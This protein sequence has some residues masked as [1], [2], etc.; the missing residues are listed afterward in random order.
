MEV[1]AMKMTLTVTLALLFTIVTLTFA[2]EQPVGEV[3][4]GGEL[5][6]RIRFSAGGMTPQQRADAITQRL[7]NIL[8]ELDIQPSGIVVKPIGGGEA[9]I[10]VKDNLLVTVD[11]KHAA[12]NK[13]T[14]FKLGEIWAKHLREV[15]PQVNVKPMR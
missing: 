5:I 8:Q 12:L 9:A 7:V 3:T 1:A 4:V 10:Y 6:L 14:P 11:K 15:L 2:Q 13:T